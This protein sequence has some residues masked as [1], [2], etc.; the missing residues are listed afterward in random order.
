ML[1]GVF[2]G[3]EA[4][5]LLIH[6]RQFLALDAAQLV[7][8]LEA[9]LVTR[10]RGFGLVDR[11][12]LCA[13][14]LVGELVFLVR[15]FVRLVGRLQ[16]LAGLGLGLL[17][18]LDAGLVLAA[19]GADLAPAQG[20]QFSFK[21][22]LLLLVFLELFCVSCLTLQGIQAGLKFSAQVI[23]PLQVF[24]RAA[25][26]GLGVTAALLVPGNA[27]GFLQPLPQ[28]L[29]LGLDHPRDHALL[30]DRVAR[31]Q[32]QAGA[33]EQV[34]DIALL[35]LAAVE[36]VLRG[37]VAGEFAA[38]ADLVVGRVGAGDLAIGVVED[39]LHAGAAHRLAGLGAVEDHIVHGLRTQG[40]HGSLAQHPAYRVDDVGLAAAIGPD[41]RGQIGRQRQVA[42]IHEGFE[43][44]QL[45]PR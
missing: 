42:G 29:R 23:E 24:A 4:L 26:P 34:G 17:E 11:G 39:Q 30:D 12:L 33:Q 38:H 20:Q 14:L 28:F 13:Q 25:N 37:A 22:T 21:F 5:D 7:G 35:A 40:A 15:G 45:D 6:L 19:F 18:L 31:A 43:T 32:A 16:L 10:Q 3:L 2:A 27:G 36:Q 44:R 9:L 8:V 41:H 1:F